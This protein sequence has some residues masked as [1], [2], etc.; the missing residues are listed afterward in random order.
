MSV[1]SVSL[2]FKVNSTINSVS[3][4]VKKTKDSFGHSAPPIGQF[5]HIS[6]LLFFLFTDLHQL[7]ILLITVLIVLAVTQLA[8]KNKEFTL[9]MSRKKLLKLLLL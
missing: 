4:V 2:L 6:K 9:L 1:E 3:R 8:A 5:W 7:L